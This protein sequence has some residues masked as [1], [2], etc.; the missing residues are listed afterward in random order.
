MKTISYLRILLVLSILYVNQSVFATK[1]VEV[2]VV[3]KGPHNA[4]FYGWRGNVSRKF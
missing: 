2:K 3:D 4:L 1:L